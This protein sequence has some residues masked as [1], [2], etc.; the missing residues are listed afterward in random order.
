MA[1]LIVTA[2]G[3]G[4]HSIEY[5]AKLEQ[6]TYECNEWTTGARRQ[7]GVDSSDSTYAKANHWCR[8]ETRDRA[9]GSEGPK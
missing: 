7:G 6:P 4:Q 8:G 3:F 1:E 9:G 5:L 2:K